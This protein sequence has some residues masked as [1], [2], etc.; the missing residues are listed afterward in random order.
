MWRYDAQRQLMSS[1]VGMLVLIVFAR[2][3]QGNDCLNLIGL[4]SCDLVVGTAVDGM[5][6]WLFAAGGMRLGYYG[7]PP[8]RRL[9]AAQ[10]AACALM[11]VAAR[12]SSCCIGSLALTAV[13]RSQTIH[14]RPE[15]MFYYVTALTPAVYF[16]LRFCLLDVPHKAGYA[17]IQSTHKTHRPA[18][19]VSPMHVIGSVEDESV[20]EVEQMPHVD[21]SGG[22]RGHR[23][24]PGA[25][26]AE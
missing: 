23:P 7:E 25:Q 8:Q 19:T 17:R 9:F 16:V 24:T 4:V 10:A 26:S 11:S 15:D 20:E 6:L 18:D 13:Y 3:L 1:V 14:Y 12:S 2:G 22:V 21:P 5:L